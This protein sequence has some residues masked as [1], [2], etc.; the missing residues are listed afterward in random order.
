VAT[1]GGGWYVLAGVVGGSAFLRKQI[2]AENVFTFLY[3]RHLS[4]GHVHPFYYVELTLLLGF[5]PWTPLLL[6]E[7]WVLIAD[8]QRFNPRD[9]RPSSER[10]RYLVVWFSAVLAFYNLAHSKRGV[11]LLALYPA[12]AT[13]L[14]VFIRDS[15]ARRSPRRVELYRWLSLIYGTMLLFSGAAALLGLAILWTDPVMFGRILNPIG[16]TTPGFIVALQAAIAANSWF[17]ILLPGVVAAL[18]SYLMRSRHS[19]Q[20]LVAA[21]AMALCTT[22]IIV[23]LYISPAIANTLSLRRFTS[24]VFQIVGSRNVAYLG[25]LNYDVAFYSGR[26]LPLASI[27]DRTLPEYLITGADYVDS[28]PESVRR[29]YEVVLRSNPT[30]LDGSVALVLL[31]RRP[32]SPSA[33]AHADNL[34]TAIACVAL[35]SL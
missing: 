2:L 29:N 15:I 7:S 5:M 18:G 10:M 4:G 33:S 6:A 27:F 3:N 35:K 20:K 34:T 28:L 30:E 11:Y 1:L 8:R 13:L 24:E 14:G 22:T 26:N 32:W 31:R 17:A 12:V 21:T 25:V 9:P 16:I 23:N 19:P